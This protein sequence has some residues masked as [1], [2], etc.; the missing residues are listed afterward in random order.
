MAMPEVKALEPVEYHAWDH[1]VRLSLSPG[2]VLCHES[3][4]EVVTNAPAIHPKR[5]ARFTMVEVHPWW[6]LEW[7]V[8]HWIPHEARC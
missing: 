1:G 3:L 7:D 8:P 4:G 2:G 5:G 6:D